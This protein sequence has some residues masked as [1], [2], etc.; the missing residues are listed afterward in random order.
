M[1]Q[2]YFKH[3]ELAL[4][5]YANLNAGTLTPATATDPKE[6]FAPYNK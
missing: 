1:N 5:A 6:K 2:E 3:A 4:A